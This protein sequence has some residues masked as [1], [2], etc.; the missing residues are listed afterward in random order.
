MSALNVCTYVRE[1]YA[2]LFVVLG[3]KVTTFGLVCKELIHLTG[4][5]I[6]SY[7]NETFVV[8]VENEVLALDVTNS[9]NTIEEG[10]KED[11]P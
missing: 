5:P 3:D 8:H 1:R 9:G 6:V 4:G 7:N 2:Y 11:L 10:I